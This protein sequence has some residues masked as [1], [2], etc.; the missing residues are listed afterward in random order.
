MKTSR[1]RVQM[2]APMTLRRG[3]RHSA[4]EAEAFPASVDGE[5]Q[6]WNR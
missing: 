6:W 1:S 5:R 3:K 2:L 4:G